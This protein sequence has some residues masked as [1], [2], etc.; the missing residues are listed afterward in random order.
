MNKRINLFQ[1]K[2]GLYFYLFMRL[3]AKNKRLK[4]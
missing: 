2:G 4:S 1:V 3:H